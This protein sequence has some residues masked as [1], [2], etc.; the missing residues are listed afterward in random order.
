MKRRHSFLTFIILTQIGIGTAFAQSPEAAKPFRIGTGLGCSF[1]GYRDEVE[2]PINRYLNALTFIIDGNI[3]KGSFFHSFNIN[4]FTGNP[5][6]AALY[7][8]YSQKQYV[9]YRGLV[10]YSLDYR[11]WGNQTFPGYLGGAFRTLFYYTGDDSDELLERSYPTGFLLFS[12]DLH[13]SQKWL[14]NKKNTLVLSIGYPLLGYAVRPAY[15]GLD[16]LWI[17]YLYESHDKII[18]LGKVT[19]FHNYW[20]VLGDLKYQHQ[21]NSWFAVYSG[22]GFELSLINFP[23]P[24]KDAIFRLDGGLAF[25]F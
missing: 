11:L 14:I 13:A 7:E 25:T 12:L 3:E 24:R 18:S 19:S 10:G 4:F 1:T 6:V 16:E 23:R 8:G 5:K 22:L 2:S 21:F 15:A 20:A 17:E 9:S